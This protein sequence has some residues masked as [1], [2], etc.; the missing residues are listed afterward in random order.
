M[1]FTTITKLFP[2]P[3]IGDLVYDPNA[4]KHWASCPEATEGALYLCVGHTAAGE[5]SWRVLPASLDSSLRSN[6]SLS[7]KSLCIGN[8]YRSLENVIPEIHK[9]F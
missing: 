5:P 2:D 3:E 7:T 6:L 4:M 8:I 9:R 1:S